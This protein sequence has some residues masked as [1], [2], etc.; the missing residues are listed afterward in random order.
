M[1]TIPPTSAANS[2]AID[3]PQKRGLAAM[4]QGDFLRLMVEQLKHQDPSDP[5]D[6]KEM[7]AQ[8]AQFSS[9][10]GTTE[11][12]ASLASIAQRLDTLIALQL[13]AASATDQTAP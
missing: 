12:N 11:T 2:A 3:A 9:L 13:Q 1:T 5:V 7:L 4:G 10:A 8:M 6:N